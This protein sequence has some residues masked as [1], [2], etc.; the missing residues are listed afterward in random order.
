MHTQNLVLLTVIAIVAALLPAGVVLTW[1]IW[2]RHMD[3]RRSPLTTEFNNLPGEHAGSQ[4][5]R[6]ME[7]A[8][9]RLLIATLIGPL[10]LAVW[11][12]QRVDPHLLRFGWS[13]AVLLVVIGVAA[14][15]AARSGAKLL[16]RRRLYLDGLAAERATAQ[17][18]TP[19]IAKGCT[20]YHDV[21][22]EKFNLDHVVIGPG[23]VFMVE[24]KSRQKP[25]GRGAANAQVR[26]D[27][28][29]LIFPDWRDTQMLDQTRG[30]ARWLSKYL[31]RKTG[32]RVRVEPVL[33]L[34]G[35]FVTCTDPAPDV[36]VI[37]P[38][39]HNFMANSDGQP[40]PEPQRRRIMT[41][42][43]ERYRV[44]NAATEASK[45]FA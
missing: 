36:H 25:G 6:L 34:P 26:F 14:L 45:D 16:L 18:L 8:N 33:A 12:F 37:N 2:K 40:I 10:A 21:P 23:K 31:Y 29:A 4:A 35:W 39:M 15:L 27:G 1:A 43:E 42:L 5:E 9:E 22:G 30:Q 20:I 32:E 11:A 24:T 19:L 44:M 13:E 28:H 41:A 17:E 38:Q 7:K 3:R